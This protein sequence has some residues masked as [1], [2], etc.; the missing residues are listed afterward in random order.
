MVSK[1]LNIFPN[2]TTDILVIVTHPGKVFQKICNSMRRP[3]SNRRPTWAF[4][5]VIRAQGM[6]FIG[7]RAIISIFLINTW[8]RDSLTLKALQIRDDSHEFFAFV[9]KYGHGQQF[10]K[11]LACIFPLTSLSCGLLRNWVAQ[12]MYWHT[13]VLISQIQ[14]WRTW[15]YFCTKNTMFFWHK[16]SRPQIKSFWNSHQITIKDKSDKISTN[17]SFHT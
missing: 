7:I 9:T 1:L 2:Y 6:R 16:L 4:I 17:K 11:P 3:F 12:R 15:S 13:F 10:S 8:S 14:A 5:S